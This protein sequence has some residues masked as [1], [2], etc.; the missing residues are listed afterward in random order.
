MSDP[1]WTAEDEAETRKRMEKPATPQKD[2]RLCMCGHLARAHSSQSTRNDQTTLYYR[3]KGEEHC[4]YARMSCPC[5]RFTEAVTV[6]DPRVGTFKT[7]GPGPDHALQK[8]VV[9]ARDQE[10]NVVF[11][12]QVLFC[13]VCKKEGV[14][15]TVANLDVHQRVSNRPEGVNVFLCDWHYSEKGGHT[16]R[17]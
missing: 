7:V 14:H 17:S 10:Q 6:D 4:A 11:N 15:L 2:G 13:A 12:P 9:K 1:L 3:N 16:P 8:A 5:V